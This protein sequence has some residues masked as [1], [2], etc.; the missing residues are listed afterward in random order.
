MI[1]TSKAYTAKQ[2]WAAYA[3]VLPKD[4]SAT[5]YRETRRAFYAGLSSML[6]IN[7][8][9]ADLEEDAGVEIMDGI[10]NECHEFAKLLKEGKA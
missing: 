7:I 8:E 1:G 6:A 9:L 5:Q 3:K 10:L 4:V 2:R